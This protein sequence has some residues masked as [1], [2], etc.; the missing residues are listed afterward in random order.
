MDLFIPPKF[1][2]LGRSKFHFLNLPSF[3][4]TS[5]SDLIDLYYIPIYLPTYL[6][7]NLPTY[8]GAY[9]RT[10]LGAYLPMCKT[11]I[12]SQ[13]VIRGIT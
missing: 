3:C 12:L 5:I 7:T 1:G 13:T 4:Q 9:L 10:Y 8:L 11:N 2:G 6:S